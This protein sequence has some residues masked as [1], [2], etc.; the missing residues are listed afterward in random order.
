MTVLYE[1]T[2][3]PTNF[4]RA[5]VGKHFEKGNSSGVDVAYPA[6]G[7][8]R[9]GARAS[10]LSIFSIM[11]NEHWLA[12]ADCPTVN[13]FE[14]GAESTSSLSPWTVAIRT[15]DILMPPYCRWVEF[16]FLAA[17]KFSST[18]D[19]LFYIQVDSSVHSVVNTNI[20][21]GEDL[22]SGKV[23]VSYETADWVKFS[24]VDV[25]ETGSA[26]AVRVYADATQHD[27]WAL[28]TVTVKVSVNVDVYAAA[29]RVIPAL[30]PLQYQS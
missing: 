8:T 13:F 12:M 27:R 25:E 28:T 16:Y 1:S 14:A 2:R 30:S 22:G 29:Y 20:P 23:A 4:Q 6:L 19:R 11:E 5:D 9:N 3:V 7:S 18:G 15:V 26:S 17:R 10:A 21:Y 24:G